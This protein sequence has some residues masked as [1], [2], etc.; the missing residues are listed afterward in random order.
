MMKYHS[1]K[2]RDFTQR[3]PIPL[4]LAPAAKRQKTE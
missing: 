2:R 1:R 3:E 4:E